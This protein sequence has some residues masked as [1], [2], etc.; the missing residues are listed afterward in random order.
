M[1]RVF[2]SHSNRDNAVSVEIMDW[3]KTR[4]FEEVFLDID[5]HAGVPPGSNWEQVLYRKIDSSQAV[6]LVVTPN[7][8]E[9]KWCFVEFAQARALG[10]AI[11]PVIVAPGGE[12]FIAPDIQQLDLQLDREG[13]LERLARELIRLGLDAQAGFPWEPGRSPY[14]GLMAFEKEDAAIFFGREDDIRALIEQ[15]SAKRVRGDLRFLAVLGA[16]GSGKSSVLRAGV[17]PRIARDRANWIVCPP[18][19][20]R[21]DPEGEFAHTVC[22]LL[23]TPEDWQQWADRFRSDE[24]AQ[25]FQELVTAARVKTGRRE[26]TLLVTIDQGEELFTL[27]ATDDFRRFVNLLL[28]AS[29]ETLPIVVVVALRSDYLD[30][31]QQ[32]AGS[33]RFD[34]FLLGPFPLARVRQIIEG[35]ARIAGLRVDLE[36]IEAAVADM[37]TDDALPLLA[38]VLRELYSRFGPL[39]GQ[40]S[41][42]SRLS[43]AHY[44]M[45]GDPASGLNPLEN[46]IQKQADKVIDG[47]RLDADATAKLRDVFVGALA[48]IDDQGRY[49]RRPA[50][51]DD[52]P[53]PVRPILEKLAEARLLVIR[54][55]GHEITVEVAHEALL[56]KWKRVRG[57]LDQERDFLIGKV[58]LRYALENWNAAAPAARDEALLQGLSL[59]RARPWLRDHASAL[60]APERDFIVASIA[61]DDADRAGRKWRIRLI[62]SAAAAMV[63]IAIVTVFT[64]REQ[65]AAT[66]QAE[67]ARLA[68][69]ARARLASDPVAAAAWAAQAVKKQE[70]ADTL[71]V[72]LESLLAI[73]PHFRKLATVADLQPGVLS[74]SLDGTFL[75]GSDQH[76][77]ALRWQPTNGAF[78]PLAAK[79]TDADT[80]RDIALTPQIIGLAAAGGGAL[81]VTEDGAALH[82]GAAQGQPTAM[83]IGEVH[84]L[85]HVAIGSTG[86]I[87]ASD[88]ES[89]EIRLYACALAGGEPSPACQSRVLARGHT[90]AVALDDEHSIAAIGFED[91]SLSIVGFGERRIFLRPQTA[92]AG[93]IASLAFNPD[94]TRIGI[95]TRAGLVMVGDVRDGAI[96]KIHQQPGSVTA[97]AW[98]PVDP[99]IAA[100]CGISSICLW[101]ASA[102]SPALDPAA[103][104]E[105]HSSTVRALSFAPNGQSLA[106]ASVD[107]TIRLWAIDPDSTYLAR[108]GGAGTAMTALAISRERSLLAAGDA[109]GNIHVW[110]LAAPQPPPVSAKI[111][112]D[113]VAA[114][115]WSPK[116]DRLA[117]GTADG[118]VALLGPPW[119]SS[120]NRFS[121]GDR[122]L[123]LRWLPSG[124]E[125]LISGNLDGHVGVY[126]L[127]GSPL[128][129]F[130]KVHADSVASLAVSPDGTRL[131]SGDVLGKIQ[132]W[133]IS[134]RLPAG[135]LL[136]TA[137]SRDT[138]EYS[139]DGSRFLV[140][141]NDGDVQIF[142]S[143]QTEIVASCRSGSQQIDAAAFSPDGDL[144]AAV[145]ADFILYLWRLGEHCELM[146][147]APLPTPSGIAAESGQLSAHRP[148]LV[149][150]PTPGIIEVTR[151]TREVLEI[152]TDPSKW[153]LRVNKFE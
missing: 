71:S 16:S 13:G 142:R 3:L 69:Q 118:S 151:S 66:V 80:P 44:R 15:L 96:A 65:Q 148:Q 92:G 111:A 106:S 72:L 74:W 102:D 115:T 77:H 42:G 144:V 150:A 39:D 5:K 132:Q 128:P 25:V 98:D 86:R 100:A 11:F 57:W 107:G 91:G 90:S 21:R 58:Q 141:G 6:I 79:A 35:P 127:D 31:L 146:A 119:T 1:A 18:F 112:G 26:A 130:D 7:W 27:S 17:L 153:L 104:F 125:V 110:S 38:F 105:G 88:R 62:R 61:R 68:V 114:L 152:S 117:A 64:W 52:V 10:K 139:R 40:S 97:L 147:S 136:D 135:P 28:R 93:A 22:D 70:S 59:N 23:G 99:L 124:S 30:R 95:G 134:D 56:R 84:A 149:F 48:R 2:V 131:L 54:Q 8:H 32:L 41:G 9:S 101:R 87:L 4:G 14:P 73:S 33:Q 12:R 129:G 43:L 113:P 63:V 133:R 46:A 36:F 116:A 67:A 121:P 137:V 51:W 24:G 123:A 55:E 60:T 19:R 82:W 83:R 50:R 120:S 20:P 103:H 29:A 94:G 109:T 138:V 122:L 126:S 75:L 143:D 49:V 145:S 78:T 37:G 53:E 140:A 85:T 89:D 81:A 45:L 108:D 47:L 76:G 34:E